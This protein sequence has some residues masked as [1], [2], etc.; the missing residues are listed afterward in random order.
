[1]PIFDNTVPMNLCWIPRQSFSLK[2]VAP[3]GHENLERIIDLKPIRVFSWSRGVRRRWDWVFV[4]SS[5]QYW[6]S[7]LSSLISARCSP[8]FLFPSVTSTRVTGLGLSRIFP[9]VI[10]IVRSGSS[11]ILRIIGC[12]F[13]CHFHEIAYQKFLRRSRPPPEAKMPHS[14]DWALALAVPTTVW[15]VLVSDVSHRVMS[16][17]NPLPLHSVK[18]S[19][20]GEGNCALGNCLSRA[21]K[22]IDQLRDQIELA[23]ALP[24]R[25][26]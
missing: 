9:D 15:M 26:P 16:L 22:R 14:Q 13:F 8:R 12:P 11:D 7:V 2:H 17:T 3:R 19:W 25:K 21:S 18:T 4:A 1:M 24:W 6:Y 23:L 10:L 20:Q 5:M